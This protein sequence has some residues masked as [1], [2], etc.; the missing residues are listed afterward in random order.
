MAYLAI[1]STAWSPLHL[2][3]F[4][5]FYCLSPF[6]SFC[7]NEIKGAMTIYCGCIWNQIFFSICCSSRDVTYTLTWVAYIKHSINIF[8]LSLIIFIHFSCEYYTKCLWNYATIQA[9]QNANVVTAFIL[10]HHK[11]LFNL[12]SFSS[13][14]CKSSLGFYYHSTPHNN[15][16]QA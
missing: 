1:Y 4:L 6:P 11:L 10:L 12:S 9:G 14:V 13:W 16:L 7:V 2:L 5:H 8:T 15:V 3:S